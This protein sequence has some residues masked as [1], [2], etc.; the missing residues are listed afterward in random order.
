M[1]LRKYKEKQ[2]LCLHNVLKEAAFVA[3]LPRKAGISVWR[4]VLG[5]TNGCTLSIILC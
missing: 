2:F 1:L 5:T 4:I 3:Q